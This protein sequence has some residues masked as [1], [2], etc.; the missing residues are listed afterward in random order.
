MK[1]A[2]GQADECMERNR[3]YKHGGSKR[4]KQVYIPAKAR[5]ASRTK[6]RNFLP[7]SC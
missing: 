5:D 1:P 7:L 3:K 2:A 6:Q 4:G